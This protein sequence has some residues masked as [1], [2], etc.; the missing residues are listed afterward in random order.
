MPTKTMPTK[1][2]NKLNPWLLAKQFQIAYPDLHFDPTRK[3]FYNYTEALFIWSP[4]TEDFLKGLVLDWIEVSYP[5]DFTKFQPHR[6]SDILILLQRKQFD[7]TKLKA[8]LGKVGFLLPFKNG[9]LNCK[10]LELKPHDKGLYSTHLIEVEYNPDMTLKDTTMSEFLACL[11]NNNSYALNIL[12][13]CLYLI[14]TNTT[15]YQ[16]AL[17][18]YGPGGTGKSTFTNILLYLFGTSAGLSTSLNMISSRFGS[19]LLKNKLLLIINEL[20][21]LLGGE[22]TILKSITGGDAITGEEKYKTATQFVP[23]LF[24]IITSNSLWNLKNVTTA[25]ARRFIYLPFINKPV[26]KN[27]ELFNFNGDGS[28]SGDLV[29]HLPA[30]IQWSLK[31][32]AEYLEELTAGGDKITENLSPDSQLRTNP[33]KVWALET[34]ELEANSQLAL[35]ANKKEVNSLHGNYLTW[36]AKYASEIGDVKSHQFSSL[37]VDN[38]TTLGWKVTKKRLKSGTVIQGIKFR[39]E[40]NFNYANQTGNTPLNFD[41]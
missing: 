31:C 2:I 11:V 7:L 19:N 38:L 34:L 35:G 40:A 16:V 39:T 24:V 29:P 22:P 5:K 28:A 33:L 17:Y 27:N 14:F 3:V 37:L 41:F 4:L 18:I 32:P 15:N 10:S 25:M 13:A 20:P 9:V 8:E 21:L 6:T 36:A 26:N 23:K 30:L 1:T 12:R